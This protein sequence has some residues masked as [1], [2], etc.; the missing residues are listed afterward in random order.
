[1]NIE[2]NMMLEKKWGNKSING[3]LG[4]FHNF[5]KS[6][7]GYEES[8]YK[9][10]TTIFS[11]VAKE[12]SGLNRVAELIDDLGIDTKNYSENL[13]KKKMGIIRT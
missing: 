10:I 2:Q 6:M 7:E 5:M 12:K 8:P 1:M 4:G 11:D 3:S 9:I 13:S